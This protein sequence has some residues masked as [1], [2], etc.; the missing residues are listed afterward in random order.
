MTYQN[1]YK[2]SILLEIIN[3]SNPAE[4]IEAFTLTIPPDN[5]EIIQSQRIS[6][7]RTFG[8]I[9]EDDYG[10]DT[11]K[12]TISGTTGNGELRTT[13]IPNVGSPQ[14]YTGKAALYTFRD[15]IIRYK[16]NL[17][18]KVLENYEM[19]YYDLSMVNPDIWHNPD[20]TT[21]I[22]SSL[23][24]WIVS[25]DD[26]KISRSKDRPLWFNYTI[27]LLGIIPLGLSR[28]QKPPELG[29][30]IPAI[31]PY[32]DGYQN[33]FLE[34]GQGSIILKKSKNWTKD[35]ALALRRALNAVR[36]AFA[37][38]QNILDEIDNVTKLITDLT[39]QIE[40]YIQA[41]GNIV[42]TGLGI[43]RRLFN[44]A[45]FPGAVA[46]SVMVETNR[47]MDSLKETIEYSDS[48]L[49]TLG[50]D[51]LQIALL[52]NE[53][54]R[55]AAQ[56]VAF[57]KSQTADSETVINLDGK[58]I[59]VYGSRSVQITSGMSLTRIASE[60]YGDPSKCVLLATYNGITDNELTPGM[61]IKVPIT[62][63]SV[64]DLDNRIFSWDKISSFGTDIKIDGNGQ[65][66]FSESGDFSVIANE[67]NLV[68]AINL[69]LNENLGNR[70]RLTTY[71]LKASV[72]FPGT[73]NAPVS[74]IITNIVD[75]LK[76]DPRIN[77][78][79]EIKL[80]GEGDQLFISFNAKTI[81]GTLNYQGVI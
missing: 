1:L 12:I 75:T 13:Y 26:F 7:T 16:A 72:G 43:Y 39:S 6:R 11:A 53:T 24:A 10:L 28:Q 30:P 65:L 60:Q 44:I 77:E 48:I 22:S 78:V 31:E 3:K 4:I 25:L 63:R 81:E 20:P 62:T 15:K 69:R 29:E 27:E 64:K 41:S 2:K 40:E 32:P 54:K 58:D 66:I 57:G 21:S 55:I 51:Y 61:E 56:I 18:T 5:I 52:A 19:R 50:D 79:E 33:L 74:Y 9:F 70:L 71:G 23:D 36:N 42:T 34:L 35:A 38:A 17:G 80:K 49:D 73:D 68:Q 47:V 14:A 67:N 37:W 46:K 76:Q 59:T 8:G 45:K